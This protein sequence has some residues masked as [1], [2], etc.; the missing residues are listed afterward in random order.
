MNVN[1][2]CRKSTPSMFLV[3]LLSSMCVISAAADDRDDPHEKS[4][5][6]HHSN[7]HLA[8]FFGTASVSGH[9]NF[10]LGSDFE[11]RLPFLAE[12]VG[13]GA[14]ADA[15]FSEHTHFMAAG[16]VFIHPVKNVKL[17]AAPG[18]AFEDGHNNFVFRTGISYDWHVNNLSISPTFN[19]D[20]S[21]GYAT[22]VFGI[23]IGA[24]L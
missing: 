20:L 12:K 8:L 1:V 6:T 5:T 21:H 22:R 17:V 14:V 13:V 24:S 10:S 23:A 18:A 4:K 11:Y 15:V 2:F 3:I 9:T 19:V 16:G 7:S